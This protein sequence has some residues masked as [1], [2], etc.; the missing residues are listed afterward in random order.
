LKKFFTKDYV[1]YVEGD[2]AEVV[3]AMM[4]AFRFD[5][6]LIQEAQPLGS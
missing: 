4:N 2:G 6:F 3:P 1:L 5:Q